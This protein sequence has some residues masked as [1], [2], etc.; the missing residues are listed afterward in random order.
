VKNSATLVTFD[1]EL[2]ELHLKMVKMVFEIGQNKS[3]SI[4]LMLANLVVYFY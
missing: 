2:D 3:F 4:L 1:G